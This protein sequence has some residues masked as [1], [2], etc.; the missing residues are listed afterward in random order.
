MN[1][2]NCC[3]DDEGAIELS[4]LKTGLVWLKFAGNAVSSRGM[5]NLMFRNLSSL[6]TDINE[7]SLELMR[8]VAKGINYCDRW[9][10]TIYLQ[11][12]QEQSSILKYRQKEQTLLSERI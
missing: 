11:A 6:L 7:D 4:K 8:L 5:K 12:H 3:I 2:D 1:V 10:F 9:G